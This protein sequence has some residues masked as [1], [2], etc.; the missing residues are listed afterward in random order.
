MSASYILANDI[1]MSG[2]DYLPIGSNEAPFTGTFDGKGYFIRN[3]SCNK[4]SAGLFSAQIRVQLKTLCLKTL[5]LNW[6]TNTAV[7]LQP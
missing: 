7:P 1:D 2:S 5:A 3:L 6:R 4:A